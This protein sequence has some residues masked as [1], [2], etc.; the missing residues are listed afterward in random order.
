MC[1]CVC[2]CVCVQRMC[3]GRLTR[4]RLWAQRALRG[5]KPTMYKYTSGVCRARVCVCVCV[6]VS[7]VTPLA[8]HLG[9]PYRMGRPPPHTQHIRQ[10]LWRSAPERRRQLHQPLLPPTRTGT[11]KRR[12]RTRHSRAILRHRCHK[13]YTAPH[14]TR[15]HARKQRRRGWEWWWERVCASQWLS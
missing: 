4:S 5:S 9:R 10:R 8:G 13:Y 6:C 2:V 1:V 12:L 3:I 14:A 15:P 11:C 7:L